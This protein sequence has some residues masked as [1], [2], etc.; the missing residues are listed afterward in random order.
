MLTLEL[1]TTQQHYEELLNLVCRQNI[2]CL[3][4]KF[5]WIQLTC[6]QFGRYFR[7]TGSTYRIRL[8]HILLGLSW[9]NLMGRTLYIYGII[10]QPAYQGRGFGQQALEL[11]E[12]LYQERIDAIELR[13]HAS[14]P[15]AKAFYERLNFE[16][17]N[18]EKDSGFYLVQKKCGSNMLN[19]SP[20]EKC[21]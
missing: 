6:D 10:I 13:V 19:R 16:V 12:S 1:A 17:I 5:D 20:V 3:E 18:Y 15:R 11:L 2:S 9:V 8:N 21:R 4:P 14:N 7:S